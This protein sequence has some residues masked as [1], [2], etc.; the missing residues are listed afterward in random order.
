[1]AGETIAV[2]G[3]NREVQ[4]WADDDTDVFDVQGKTIVP[5]LIE[6]HNH[7][8]YGAAWSSHA[9]CSSATCRNLEDVMNTIA[10]AANNTPAGEWVQG[11]GCDDT[12]SAEMRHLTRHDLDAVSSDHPIFIR[13]VSGHLAYLNSMALEQ[14]GIQAATPDPEGGTIHRDDQGEPSGLLLEN[15]AFSVHPHLP[16][17]SRLELKARLLQKIAEFN[18]LGL[19][20]THDAALGLMASD[21][22]SICSELEQRQALNIRIY[23]AVVD[24]VYNKFDSLGTAKRFGSHFFK[25][26]GVKLFQDGS[27]QGYTGALLNEYR[28]RPGWKGELIYPQ[29][30]LNEKIAYHHNNG[31]QIVIHGNGDA[32]IESIIQAFEAAQAVHPREDTRHMLIH[33]QMA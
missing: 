26:G 12:A 17:V 32:A 33:C 25:I 19:T 1:M 20:S 22:V 29:Q 18:A 27:I 16:K 11:F 21:F 15:A 13:H 10:D 31:D 4:R 24:E 6:S 2:I 3:S 7:I 28:T 8:S 23:T 14:A 9:D 30:V 5:G